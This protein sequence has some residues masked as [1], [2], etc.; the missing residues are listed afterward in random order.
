[1]F[2][3][4]QAAPVL[5]CFHASMPACPRGAKEEK[6]GVFSFFEWFLQPLLDGVVGCHFQ[7][8]M[9]EHVSYIRKRSKEQEDED[10]QQVKLSPS[11]GAMIPHYDRSSLD[12][13]GYRLRVY[14]L[15]LLYL[16]AHRS[17]CK[18]AKCRIYSSTYVR[19]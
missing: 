5:P 16:V 14:V 10:Q 9:S 7:T 1:M 4:V 17:L 3:L 15:I 13:C 11:L 18:Y 8:R 12:L 2:L 19:T 6:C